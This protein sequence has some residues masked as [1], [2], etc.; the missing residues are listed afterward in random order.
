MITMERT[1]HEQNAGAMWEAEAAA[2]WERI[3]ADDPYH[4]QMIGAACSMAI[5]VDHLDKAVDYLLDAL[6]SV[7]NTPMEDRV[8]SL[9]EKAEDLKC[10]VDMHK[11]G[12]ERGER[13]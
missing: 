4:D 12:Y 11:D 5:A 8:R 13:E 2:E 9:L 7:N 3:N 6:N 1:I 10:E